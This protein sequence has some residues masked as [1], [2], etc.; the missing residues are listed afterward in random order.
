LRI[1]SFVPGSGSS[2]DLGAGVRPAGRTV[3]S[4]AGSEIEHNNIIRRRVFILIVLN[5]LFLAIN[6]AY[7]SV[8][9]EVSIW[10]GCFFEK[11]QS[12]ESLDVGFLLAL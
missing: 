5:V 9:D 11:V 10:N 4:C 1:G 3:L 12:F 7:V 6:L 8:K 2:A